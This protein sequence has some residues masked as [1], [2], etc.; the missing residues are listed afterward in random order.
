[1]LI[2]SK[3]QPPRQSSGLIQ[4]TALVARLT[5]RDLP[6]LTVINAPPGYGKSALLSQAH[7]EWT[8][9]GVATAWYSADEGKIERDQFFAYLMAALQQAGLPLPYP[10]DVVQRGLPGV[11][12]EQAARA[13]VVALENS[14]EP[15]RIVI[16]D[17]HRVAT[18][19]TDQFL[20]YVISRMPRHAAMILATR[21]EPSF[22][23]ARLRAADAVQLIDQRDL[24]FSQAE[25]ELFLEGGES[26]LPLASG[27][28]LER[29]EGWAAAMQ[30]LRLLARERPEQ[31]DLA[32]PHCGS[33]DLANY[34]AEQLF[35][36]LPADLRHFLISTSIVAQ[37]NAGL[38]DAILERSDSQTRL[39]RLGKLN[40]LVAPDDETGE[41]VRYHPLLAD[42]LRGMLRAHR[43][44]DI[45]VLHQRAA[46][47]FAASG[48]LSEALTHAEQTGNA[49]AALTILEKA[50]GW[51]L[52]LG[53]GGLA[54]LRCFKDILPTAP[55]HYP[56]VWLGQIYLAGQEG[57]IERARAM[58]ERLRNDI[59][60]ERLAGDPAL[61]CELIGN[62]IVLRIY[63]DRPLPPEYAARLE[64]LLRDDRLSP[65]EAAFSTQLLCLLN[66]ECRDDARCRAYGELALELNAAHG[67]AH[68]TTYLFQYL[69]L[70]QL[71]Q[72]RRP[73]AEIFFR[74]AAEHAT[75]Y[76]G[77]GSHAVACAHI[78]L[79]RTNY[80]SEKLGAAQ[81]L[82][83]PAL[84]RVEAG[85]GWFD[86][87]QN[88]Y[89][90][91]A[92]IA[93][94]TADRDE[95]ER[96][97]ER[98]A[99]LERSRPMSRLAM[100]ICVARVRIAVWFGDVV[101]VEDSLRRLDDAESQSN[102]QDE[103]IACAAA[104]A[105]ISAEV[106]RH[107]AV[108]EE[109]LASLRQK[110]LDTKS[111]IRRAE[112][113]I[114]QAIILAGRGEQKAALLALRDAIS[115][116]ASEGLGSLVSQFGEPLFSRL[117]AMCKDNLQS[118]S[119][120]ERSFLTKLSGR[121]AERHGMAKP[122]PA[123]DVLVTPREVEVLRGLADG[124]SS[125]EI[126]R[127]LNIAES[128]VKTH[129]MN[130]YR[131]LDVATRSRAIA[132]A[133]GFGFL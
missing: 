7:E 113:G 107:G 3:L 77:E 132:K 40:F 109:A 14:E 105:R 62:D 46:E 75:R 90:T 34:L 110:A 21:I 49:D 88:A 31:L 16:D 119:P 4:R 12:G 102:R 18:R 24:R 44:A 97:L 130:L 86:I 76:F 73:E 78:L 133:R 51:R 74:R 101:W 118:F 30:L 84:E 92:W 19:I 48:R 127:T 47:W 121:L 50:G 43:A 81:D 120:G 59:S 128:T 83:A 94:R 82:I 72:G 65:A 103:E 112:A 117:L 32:A 42:F 25:A 26:G 35:S 15:V 36:S 45:P 114:L 71:R 63:E 6:S 55:L 80:L 79:A 68:A 61:E 5:T 69:G 99:R 126:A 93:A 8:R 66:Y 57:H 98:A 9:Q 1:M 123:S 122:P 33:S 91:L 23:L 10:E 28:L 37:V 108:D 67:M 11:L 54:L 111:L 131:K 53:G 41:W 17:Y 89:V 38:A 104:I 85:E 100:A 115:P 64:L 20:D 95:A 116:L 22:S 56:R 52:G 27:A 2:R 124:M 129:R 87:Y 70:V 39:D 125:K 13:L 29:T 60:A 106:L 58:L 96:V